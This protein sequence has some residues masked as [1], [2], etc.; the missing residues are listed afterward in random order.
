MW[1][2][3]GRAPH[4]VVALM[5]T[6]LLAGMVSL[7]A[8]CGHSSSSDT[9]TTVTTTNYKVGGSITGLTSGSVVLANGTDTVTVSSG[10]S[11]WQF[12]TS[13]TAGS[14]YDVTIKTQP[15]KELCAVTSGASGTDTG[16][17]GNVTVVCGYGEWTW[18]GG[19]STANASGVY[20][21][22]GTAATSNV[23]GARYGS[24]SW[25]D[26]SGHFWLFGGVGYDLTSATGY[27]NDLW[28]YDT[29][30]KA[31]TWVAGGS[32][33]NDAGVY[34]TLGTAAVG[35]APGGRDSAASWVDSSGNLWLFGGI[36]YD[37]AGTLGKL[38]DLWRYSP[39]TGEW[40]WIS[41]ASTVNGSGVY[42]TEGSAAAGN[43]PGARSSAV[44]W[45]DSSGNLWLFG[46]AG[47]AA[48]GSAAA[49]NDLWKLSPSSGQWTW[50]NGGNGTNASGVYGTQSTA[51]TSNVPGARYAASAW[52]DSSGD[53]WLFGGD[54]YDSAGSLGKL[55][56]LWEFSTSTGEWTWIGGE[57]LVNESGYYDSLGVTSSSS[58]PGARQSA[59]SWID[60]S[61]DLWL[62]GGMGYDANGTV[63]NLSDLWEFSPS[64]KEWT[65]KS[66]ADTSNVS[67]LY[68]TEGTAAPADAAGGRNSLSSWLDSS[69]NLWLF[70]GEGY[71]STGTLGYLNDLWLYNPSAD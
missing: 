46:G 18:E 16:D 34:G 14:S 24:S 71:D 31:W 66:G 23:P 64:T 49:L 27:L 5:P 30:S 37:S 10:A 36:G 51:A 45:V 65:W 8:G 2:R 62:F 69:G 44:S 6:L 61:G 68:G 12:S 54:G 38:N 42:G 58:V 9:T 59:T 11:S 70:G 48:S 20:G 32:S 4:T 25:T 50:V 63:G 56:D 41:G 1:V 3:A 67:G 57:D 21:T 26:S 17:V 15:S 28:E 13:Y 7:L 53:L 29:S 22:Q 52:L 39:S 40:T 43:G 35:N 55:N 19:A 60:S 33:H 47:Y